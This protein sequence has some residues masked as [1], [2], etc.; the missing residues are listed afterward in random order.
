MAETTTKEDVRID[1]D[2][3]A[4]LNREAA[5]E[6]ER[7]ERDVKREAEE[8][9]EAV[10]GDGCEKESVEAAATA[11]DFEKAEGDTE[12]IATDSSERL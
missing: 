11:F 9:V 3:A 10:D 12:R 7:I 1:A 5:D 2:E 6:L 8:Y 4:E